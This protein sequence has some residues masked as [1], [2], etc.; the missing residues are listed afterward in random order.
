[1]ADLFDV[2]APKKATNLSLN[3]DLSKKTRDLKVN[4]SETLKQALSDKLKTIETEKWKKENQ[5]TVSAYNEFVAENV[6]L[7]DEYRE[8]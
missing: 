2:A 3:S 4:L 5:A 8:F 7:G 6:C 1:M